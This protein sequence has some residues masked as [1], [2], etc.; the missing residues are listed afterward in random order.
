MNTDDLSGT[1]RFHW[2]A[3]RSAVKLE[4]LGMKRSHSPSA[5]TIAI[6]ELKLHR[7]SNYDDVISAI[8]MKLGE[9]A[10]D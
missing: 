4:K 8:S 6:R 3:L 2:L 9:R 7:N 1:I 10:N 5:K